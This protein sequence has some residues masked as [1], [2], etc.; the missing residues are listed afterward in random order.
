MKQ[1]RSEVGEVKLVSRRGWRGFLIGAILG[2]NFAT[3]YLSSNNSDYGGKSSN[4]SSHRSKSDAANVTK[5]TVVT[6]GQRKRP[7]GDESGS[8]SN[9]VNDFPPSN[10]KLAAVYPLPAGPEPPA[11]CSFSEPNQSVKEFLTSSS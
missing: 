6:I 7:S 1:C 4:E 5:P 8:S 9:A 10:P 3:V 2:P 11:R